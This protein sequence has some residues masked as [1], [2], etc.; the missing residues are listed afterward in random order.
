[1][2]QVIALGGWAWIECRTGINI[3]ALVA[4]IVI[5]WAGVWGKQKQKGEQNLPCNEAACMIFIV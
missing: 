1:M 2:A 3:M 4:Q 5:E